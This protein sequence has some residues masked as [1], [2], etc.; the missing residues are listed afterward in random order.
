MVRHFLVMSP[1]LLILAAVFE[2]NAVKL[3]DMVFSDRYGL[4]TLEDHVHGVGVAGYF[5]LI[6][7]GERLR[8][9]ARE[10]LFYFPI[11]ELC[12]FNRG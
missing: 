5:L 8:L 1:M 12:T 10:Q 6:A 2:K 7:A 4:E 11:A 3:L 9:H